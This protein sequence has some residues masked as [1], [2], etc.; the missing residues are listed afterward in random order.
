M[1]SN[2][3]KRVIMGSLAMPTPAYD[4]MVKNI[5]LDESLLHVA[6]HGKRATWLRAAIAEKCDRDEQ[7]RKG[8]K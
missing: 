8:G 6:E 4:R 2:G 5:G 3:K 1:S 7:A